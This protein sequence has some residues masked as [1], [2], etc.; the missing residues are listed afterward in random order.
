MT[1]RL[2]L[3]LAAALLGLTL[4]AC[5][6]G[7]DSPASVVEKAMQAMVEMN[8]DALGDYLCQE[9]LEE[10]QQALAMAKA[11]MEQ[12]K[13]KMKLSDMKYDLVSETEDKAMVHVTGTVSISGLGE[14]VQV[15]SVDES[16][17][18]VKIDG[19]WKVCEG[20]L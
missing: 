1:K 9:S 12:Q 20:F 5:G 10:A 4:F 2:T 6:G 14:E 3:I 19:K 16:M 17:E 18:V 11:M 8:G 7:G 13:I 15:D